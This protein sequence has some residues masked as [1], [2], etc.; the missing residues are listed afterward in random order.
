M[1]R[2]FLDLGEKMEVKEC[3]VGYIDGKYYL[4]KGYYWKGKFITSNY[5]QDAYELGYYHGKCIAKNLPKRKLKRIIRMKAI[6]D[7][8]Q[9][10]IDA[11]RECLNENK[12]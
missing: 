11:I 3:K 6:N 9:G 2:Y 5:G 1:L 8:E 10:K 7:Y 4:G 12:N